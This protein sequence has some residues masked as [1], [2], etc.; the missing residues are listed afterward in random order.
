MHFIPWIEPKLFIGSGSVLKLP[1]LMKEKGLQRI[2]IVTDKSLMMINM[3]DELF[4]ALEKAGIDYFVYDSVQPNPTFEN[5]EDAKQMYLDNN[6]QCLV[7]FGGGSPMDCA[8]ATSAKI[9]R[10]D[11]PLEKMSGTFRV[12][13][14]SLKMTSIL[15]PALWA[16]PTTAGTGSETTVAA[17]VSDPT[18]HKKF[19]INDPVIRPR[20]AF[21][22][23]D[24]TKTLPKG[25]TST[26]GMDALTHAVEAY[27]GRSN[28]KDTALKAKMA[29]KMIYENIETAYNDGNNIEA[30]SQMLL[31]SYYAGC[32]FTRA[33]VGYVH[34]IA[35]NL[36]GFYG[37]PHGLANAVIM[38]YV[39]E[40]YGECIHK[41]L[42][43]LAECAGVSNPE[44][45][46]G[47]NAKAFIDSIK[48]L[49]KKMDIG[50]HFPEIQEKD[51]ETIVIRAFKEAHPN[52][53]VPKIMN[54]EDCIS[55]IR[56]IMSS[57]Q[58]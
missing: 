56:Q 39:L 19:P 4:E 58:M 1:Q 36:G 28:T 22:D 47:Q 16:I 49:N 35:H 17:V 54:K 21:L 48:E 23:P 31:A 25:M 15:P 37:I 2:L 40:W 57:N 43:Q 12:L 53:P 33:Y 44:F 26:T 51:I 13:L 55:V 8:K 32:A 46:D 7:A 27:I 18:T 45:T 9:S 41:R 6:C 50:D 30:R 5:I 3:L 34:A 24:L 11:R 42:A 38:P 10:P 20:Y 14:P 52:Y 29:V